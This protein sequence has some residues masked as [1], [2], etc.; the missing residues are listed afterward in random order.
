MD[1]PTRTGHNHALTT[2]QMLAAARSYEAQAL[3]RS[4]DLLTGAHAPEADPLHA[5]AQL[6]RQLQL[7][8]PHFPL[9]RQ[10]Y[11]NEYTADALRRS[12]S[13]ALPS[14]LFAPSECACNQV[15]LLKTKHF[16]PGL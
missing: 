10:K 13:F 4:R 16:T 2:R 14:G 7:L 9:Q 1:S 11:A 12:I 3:E 15:E 8:A 5:Q 6:S